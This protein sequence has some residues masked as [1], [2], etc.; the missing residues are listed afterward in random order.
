MKEVY[1]KRLEMQISQET[2]CTGLEIMKNFDDEFND[3]TKNY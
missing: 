3:L 2:A 1:P